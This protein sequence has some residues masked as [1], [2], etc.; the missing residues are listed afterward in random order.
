MLTGLH[1]T[2]TFYKYDTP[3]QVKLKQEDEIDDISFILGTLLLAESLVTPQEAAALKTT[4]VSSGTLTLEENEEEIK[5]EN[6][7]DGQALVVSKKEFKRVFK[8][9]EH[10]E[11]GEFIFK[12][13]GEPFFTSGVATC[14]AV[15]VKAFK[16][17]K[18]TR[19]VILHDAGANLDSFVRKVTRVTKAADTVSLSIYGGYDKSPHQDVIDKFQEVS[20]KGKS[21]KLQVKEV[22]INPWNIDSNSYTKYER[23]LIPYEFFHLFAGVN[24]EGKIL[25]ADGSDLSPFPKN[26]KLLKVPDPFNSNFLQYQDPLVQALIPKKHKK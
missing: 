2:Y 24:K 4:I 10:V 26:A 25:I 7:V 22:K 8:K 13:L 12:K 21:F 5:L 14:N 19:V 15:I 17:S 9:S 6:E 3:L 18:C 20:N 16:D 23:I 11:Q 1:S